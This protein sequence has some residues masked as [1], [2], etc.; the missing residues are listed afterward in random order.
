MKFSCII[1]AYNEWP[2]IGKVL[3]TVLSCDEIEEVI[4]VDD[5]STDNTWE[6]LSRVKNGKLFPIHSDKNLGKAAA[7]LRGVWQ[8]QWEYIVMIDSDLLHF[9][10]EHVR[11]L[12]RPILEDKAHVTL[13]LRENSLSLYK[14]FGTDFVSGERVMPKSIFEDEWYFLEGPGFWLEV[15][16]NQKIMERNFKVKNVYLPW[17]ITP[18]KSIKYGWIVGTFLDWKMVIA[19]LSSIPLHVIFR[20]IWYFSRF[21]EK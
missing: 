9:N 10:D 5:G 20:Q 13:S 3:A 15:K 2:R 7:V 12:I 1:P 14:F 8:A 6:V 16:I 11:L 19:I 17:V 21:S 18:R 4:V